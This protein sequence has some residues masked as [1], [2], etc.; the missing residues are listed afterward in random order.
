MFKIKLKKKYDGTIF[1][2]NN[3]DIVVFKT[4]YVENRF[5]YEAIFLSHPEND[6]IGS[7]VNNDF[8]EEKITQ[9]LEQKWWF[10]HKNPENYV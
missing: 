7:V 2:L 9:F 8:S 10:K 4:N 1:C 5:C 6:K 3:E